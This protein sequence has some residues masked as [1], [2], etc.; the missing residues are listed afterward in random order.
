MRCP[1]GSPRLTSRPSRTINGPDNV[2]SASI[3]GTSTCQPVKSL[4]LNRLMVFFEFVSSSDLL[5]VPQE[6]RT[7]QTSKR[8]EK[9]IAGFSIDSSQINLCSAAPYGGFHLRND[10]LTGGCH[11][12]GLRGPS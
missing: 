3:S 10:S 5:A 11:G 2:E 12:L 4:P 8:K 7:A 6:A 1:R 9:R